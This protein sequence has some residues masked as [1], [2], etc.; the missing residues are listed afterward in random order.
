MQTCSSMTGLVGSLLLGCLLGVPWAAADEPER[1]GEEPGAE[2]P[3]AL[4]SW[5]Q[6][7]RPAGAAERRVE[8]VF[9]YADGF[10]H[11][12]VYDPQGR[13]LED[14]PLTG[15]QPTP[16]R[17]EIEEAFTIVRRDPQLRR[18][19]HDARGQLDGG[20]LYEEGTNRPC[21]PGSRCLQVFLLGESRR[22]LVQHIVVDLM[23]REVVYR[24]DTWRAP[25]P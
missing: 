1:A 23:R 19:M 5:S 4:R 16:S 6:P 7:R 14:Q 10:A 20:F 18:R 2:A 17:A 3:R 21:G 24:G 12:R 25:D 13:L 8:V 11:R 9:D 22:V 15:S